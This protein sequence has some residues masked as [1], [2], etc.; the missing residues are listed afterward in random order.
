MLTDTFAGEPNYAFV[1]RHYFLVSE[2]TRNRCLVRIAKSLFNLTNQ[3][4]ETIEY[5]DSIEI[6]PRNQN[7]VCFIEF[8]ENLPQGIKLTDVSSVFATF[9]TNKLVKQVA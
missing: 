2:D 6:R 8:P 3:R 7:L 1:Q 4:G 5:G 9:A